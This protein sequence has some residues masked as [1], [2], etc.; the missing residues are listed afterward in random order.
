MGAGQL[1]GIR[2]FTQDGI[3]YRYHRATGI[4][5]P[6]DIPE[7]HPDFLKA[8][9]AAEGQI[10][11]ATAP[12]KRSATPRQGTI[13]HAWWR[14]EKSDDFL[15]LSE[16]Y[17]DN[18]KRHGDAIIKRGGAVPVNQVRPHHIRNDMSDLNRNAQRVR[19]KAWRMF[20]KWLHS[21]GDIEE[22]WALQVDMP[23]ARKPQKHRKWD[24][25]HVT[26]F[27]N[28]WAIGTS[29]RL[30]MEI[31]LFF[32]CRICDAVRIGPGMVIEDGWLRYTQ[33]KTKGLVQVPFDRTLPDFADQEAHR[34]LKQCIAALPQR[35]MTWL[36]TDYGA[37]RSEKGAS[38]WFS[39]ACREA[40]LKDD[41]RRTGHGLRSTC[42]VRMAE[43]SA[44]THQI[45]AWTGHESLSEIEGYTKEVNSRTLLTADETRTKIVQVAKS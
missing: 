22:K 9:L 34:F 15:D 14:F 10:G 44:T 1:K 26:L 23:S 21:Q 29:Q 35:H 28:R 2:R 27:R 17:R 13:G 36:T 4:R 45:G 20:T 33:K 16:G 8:Y 31:M 12:T 25:R 6:S 41:D 24:V 5:L 3:Q 40:N 38:S 18:I 30:A 32:G 42:E 11:S 39:A 7:Q 37:A 19:L 43:K